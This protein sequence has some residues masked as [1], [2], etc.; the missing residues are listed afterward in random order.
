MRPEYLVVKHFFNNFVCS[1]VEDFWNFLYLGWKIFAAPRYVRIEKILIKE[2]RHFRWDSFF[3]ILTVQVSAT[4]LKFSA[5]KML[6]NYTRT[7]YTI[8]PCVNDI[9]ENKD[10]PHH[11]VMKLL[12]FKFFRTY[13]LLLR[14]ITLIFSF[15][16]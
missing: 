4:C 13:Y 15:F 8:G 16:F 5:P 2:H 1:I 14:G 9:E 12:A 11:I 10:R 3:F 7:K 6:K